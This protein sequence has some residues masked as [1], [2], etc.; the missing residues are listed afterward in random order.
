MSKPICP[1]DHLGNPLA[2]GDLV[3]TVGPSKRRGGRYV[4]LWCA[5]VIG[6]TPKMV[7]VKYKKLDSET[8][9]SSLD[10]IR[11]E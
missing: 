7:E 2:V 6:F 11:I 1:K 4:G 8:K 9:V 3:V 10:C 5:Q